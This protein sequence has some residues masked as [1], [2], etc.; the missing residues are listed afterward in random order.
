MDFDIET[1][2]DMLSLI[3][4]MDKQVDVEFQG[5]KDSKGVINPK[6]LALRFNHPQINE[7]LSKWE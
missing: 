5:K 2:S 4:K 1:V 6:T 3:F 7:G